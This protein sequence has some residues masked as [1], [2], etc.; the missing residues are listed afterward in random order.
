MQN[1]VL[2]WVVAQFSHYPLSA[3]DIRAATR[4]Q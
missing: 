4:E 1:A 2:C 3:L